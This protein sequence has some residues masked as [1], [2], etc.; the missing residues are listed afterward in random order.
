LKHTSSKVVIT[1]Y[2]YN[3]ERRILIRKIK[4]LESILFPLSTTSNFFF[5]QEN[6]NNKLL[7][8]KEKLNIIK[9]Q[10]KTVSLM[11]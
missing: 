4:R 11:S 3:E 9:I 7:S 10:E 5:K 6:S 2:I 1:L 8:I